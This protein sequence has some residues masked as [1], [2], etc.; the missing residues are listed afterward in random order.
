MEELTAMMRCL[1]QKFDLQTD[2]IRELKQTIP[3]II[4]KNINENFMNLESKYNDLQTIVE[5]Q[6]RRIQI[7][8]RSSR[9]KNIVFFGVEES[10]KNYFELQNKVLEIINQIMKIKCSEE[11]IEDVR[12]LGKKNGSLRPVVITLSTVGIKIKLLKNRKTL[13]GS[14]YYIKEDFP[15]D[16]LEERKNLKVQLQEEKS[17]GKR[18]ILRYNKLIILP[19]KNQ[20]QHKINQD[21]GNRN[22]RTLSESPELLNSNSGTRR[23]IFKKPLHNTTASIQKYMVKNPNKK[24]QKSLSM[25][26]T[27][28]ST[29]QFTPTSALE[30]N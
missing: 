23:N 14:P 10:E 6:G 13:E 21:T 30:K 20:P 29:S 5:Q 26:N 19:E 27:A 4:S 22:K 8:E 3:D 2:E 12:R 24:D 17:K 7:L 16:I 11:N 28:A 9:K 18:A 15:P 25:S 1:Q